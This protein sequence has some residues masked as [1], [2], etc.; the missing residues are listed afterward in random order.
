MKYIV[1]FII[2]IISE[3]NTPQNLLRI[4]LNP[5]IKTYKALSP[6]FIFLATRIPPPSSHICFICSTDQSVLKVYILRILQEISHPSLS[7]Y[8][9]VFLLFFLSPHLF[10]EIG[11]IVLQN[12]RPMGHIAHLSNTGSYE[13][14]F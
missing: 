13:N 10:I 6:T 11:I 14:I 4:P 5:R 1:K 3:C 7:K 2:G 12:K 9:Q 8:Q